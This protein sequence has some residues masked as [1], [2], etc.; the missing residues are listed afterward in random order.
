[1]SSTA[2]T[3]VGALLA[4]IAGGVAL[5]AYALAETRERLARL[6]ALLEELRYGLAGERR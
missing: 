2:A 1:M 5:L 3:I 4:V 6:E